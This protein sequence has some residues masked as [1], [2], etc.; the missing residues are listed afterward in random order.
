ML[1]V[2]AA[3]IGA[4]YLLVPDQEQLRTRLFK[5]QIGGDILA[6]I[7]SGAFGDHAQ[8]RAEF[9]RMSAEQLTFISQLSRL[10]PRERL[11]HI[12]SPAHV[13]DY[14]AFTHH[15]VIAAVRY[16]DVMKPDEAFALAAPV[17]NRIPGSFRLQL[18]RLLARNALAVNSPETAARILREACSTDSADW[19]TISDLVD[20]E[21]WTNHPENA[22][23]ALRAWLDKHSHQLDPQ[24]SDTANE[25]LFK[26]A[27]EANVPGI[28]LDKCM[29]DLAALPAGAPIPEVLMEQA[30]KASESAS[31][32]EEILPWIERHL[33]AF[34]EDKLDWS[35]LMQH[36]RSTQPVSPGY[37]L[38]TQRAAMI[39]DWNS[40]A[41]HACRHHLRLVAMGVMDSLDRYLSLASYLGQSEELARLLESVGPVAGHEDLPLMLARHTASNGDAP[42]A[43]KL[44]TEW[45]A[46]HPD[47]Q[48]ARWEHACLHESITLSGEAVKTFDKLVRDYPEDGRA[49]KRSATL[50]QSQAKYRE[51][52]ARLDAL[53][54]DAFDA[55]TLDDYLL[56]AESLDDPTAMK[57]GLRLKLALDIEPQPADWLRLADVVRSVESVDACVTVLN[58]AIAAMPD[59]PLL[60]SQFAAILLQDER[61]DEAVTAALHPAAW[62]DMDARLTALSACIHTSRAAEVLHALGD[63]FPIKDQACN[64]LLDLAVAYRQSGQHE[65]AAALFAMVP[66][67]PER[68]YHLAQAYLL[69]GD[70]EQASR[71]ANLNL[72]NRTPPESSDWVLLGDICHK[73][74]LRAQAHEAYARAVD[75]VT[76]RLQRR[77][78]AIKPP[79]DTGSE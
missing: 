39:S 47:D 42:K 35:T 9:A 79:Q 59:V 70:L 2:V 40:L 29:A 4:S 63:D 18:F 34:T 25:M 28:A 56:L 26:L 78:A 21:R 19:Q 75:A 30:F 68:C 46:Q 8:A 74:G 12:F 15:Y 72:K 73:Q 32:T 41:D 48:D 11:R 33:R 45:I 58:E 52:L 64:T 10:T 22:C 44:Y 54:D 71:L 77:T 5:D 61:Y 23:A 66:E 65:R 43:F 24:L 36:S 1:A 67:T 6:L 17:A 49:I 62:T 53:S 7:D 3:S 57:R 38:W 14:D 13:D 37:Q 31:K 69:A 76:T 16:V 55:D 60:R 51:S 20:A 50:L 27:L